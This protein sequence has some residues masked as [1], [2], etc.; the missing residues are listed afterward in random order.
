MLS[1]KK[2]FSDRI[3]IFFVIMAQSYS[4]ISIFTYNYVELKD[5]AVLLLMKAAVEG[6]AY[7]IFDRIN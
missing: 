4:V 1:A 3:Y 5:I 2:K 7:F 6:K